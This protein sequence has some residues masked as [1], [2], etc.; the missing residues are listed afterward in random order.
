MDTCNIG[1]LEYNFSIVLLL[2]S[3]HEAMT[4]CVVQ[5]AAVYLFFVYLYNSENT[6]L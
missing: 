4:L 5:I 1:S 2:T 3:H 6:M